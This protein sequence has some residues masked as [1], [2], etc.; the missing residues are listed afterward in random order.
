MFKKDDLI[1]NNRN[2]LNKVK[3]IENLKIKTRF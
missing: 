2:K 3:Y 1:L